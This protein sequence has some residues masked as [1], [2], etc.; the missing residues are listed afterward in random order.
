MSL[1]T[2][3]GALELMG[4]SVVLYEGATPMTQPCKNCPF[5]AEDRGEGYLTPERLEEIQI[6]TLL[7][8]PFWCHKSVYHKAVPTEID[9]ETGDEEKPGYDRRYK[10]CAGATA[11]ARAFV[12]GHGG[13]V[14]LHGMGGVRDDH[15]QG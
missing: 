2:P 15:D 4:G 6:S 14:R 9:P 7:G 10:Q 8:Q 1:D 13:K 11:W 3:E 5:P 12:K